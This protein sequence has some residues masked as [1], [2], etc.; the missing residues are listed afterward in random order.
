MFAIEGVTIPN[1]DR[2]AV[3]LEP[4]DARRGGGKDP[5]QGMSYHVDLIEDRVR[6]NE[7]RWDHPRFGGCCVA[8]LRCTPIWRERAAR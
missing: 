1:S 8:H 2:C 7:F 3:C 5:E 6:A 4:V